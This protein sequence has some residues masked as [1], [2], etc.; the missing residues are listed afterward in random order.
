V[1]THIYYEPLTD[2]VHE[3]EDNNPATDWLIP[4]SDIR[5]TEPATC[6]SGAFQ[7]AWDSTSLSELK[8]CPRKYQYSILQGWTHKILPPPLSFGIHFHTCME[9]WHKLIT[10]HQYDPEDALLRVVKLAGLLGETIS[11]GD[12]ARTKETL[13]RSALWYIDNFQDDPARTVE[14][15]NGSPAVEYS[16]TLPF[17]EIDGI[18]LYLTGHIDRLVEFHGD[19]YPTDYKTTKR[20]LDS[21]F[22][23]QFKPNIQ[24]AHYVACCAVMAHEGTSIPSI[25][26]GIIIDGIQLGV[27][28][29]RFRRHIVHYQQ[30]E[31][32]E[33]LNDTAMWIETAKRYA[34]DGYWPKNEKACDM[35]GGCHFREICRTRPGQRHLALKTNFTQ[36]T[37][38]PLKA[39]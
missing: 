17:D 28:F 30:D 10:L 24:T 19:V 26:K 32:E 36:R 5:S 35:Y 38:D 16:F 8:T 6:F 25:P 18:Q 15:L 13:I 23:D 34:D 29:S 22:F 20:A 7:F 11:A 1:T 33:Y 2:V 12:T 3:V 39:R 4:I 37:W 21:R 27:N 14:L 9:T 31:I